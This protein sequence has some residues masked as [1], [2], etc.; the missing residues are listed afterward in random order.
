MTLIMALPIRKPNVALESY[1]AAQR[2]TNPHTA[3]SHYVMALG[4]NANPQW[5]AQVA[6]RAGNITDPL[7]S[8]T[9]LV[10]AS[11]YEKDPDVLAKQ[12][13]AVIE[14]I[15]PHTIPSATRLIDH[16]TIEAIAR[17]V[18]LLAPRN[19]DG[20][21]AF[22]H[23]KDI[24]TKQIDAIATDDIATYQT[25]A[26]VMLL[27]IVSAPHNGGARH[28]LL[29]MLAASRSAII[30]ERYQDAFADVLEPKTP[31]TKAMAVTDLKPRLN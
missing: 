25:K 8:A 27:N 21:K 17:N 6:A 20:E 23:A 19:N 18:F 16:T 2:D 4:S 10:L 29:V 30:Q 1:A 15:K 14:K 22:C 26:S 13:N 28:S 12:L 31:A 11:R 7:L 9:Y 3:Y 5:V 24:W